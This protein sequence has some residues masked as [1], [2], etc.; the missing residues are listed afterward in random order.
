MSASGSV[1]RW[2]LVAERA[3]SSAVVVVLLPV[4]DHD[5]GLG[6]VPEDVD[7]QAFVADPAVERLDVAVAPRLT[8]GTND[9]PTRSPAQSAI[10]AQ[11]TSGPLSQRS[12][13]G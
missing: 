7:V 4:G 9:R 8:G 3:V 12:A 6:Q 5:A 2:G 13:V 10:A 1:D 11:A